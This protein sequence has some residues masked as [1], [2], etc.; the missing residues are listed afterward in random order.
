MKQ[1]AALDD[2]LDDSVEVFPGNTLPVPRTGLSSPN[3]L[4]PSLLGFPPMLPV[5]LAMRT[6]PAHVVCAAYE[7]NREEFE[8]IIEDPV[9]I[10]AF[11][12]AQEALTKDGASFKLKAKLQAES[13]LAKSWS[14]IHL[15]GTPAA[16]KADLI[17]STV[18]WAEYEPKKDGGAGLNGNNF[19]I[20]IDLGG[21]K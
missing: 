8:R 17:K 18:R 6:Y 16:V 14:M 4:D 11:R 20:N 21:S 13:L 10:V 15:D 12:A 7:I 5:E 19:Q 9:F 3:P 2:D 1:S